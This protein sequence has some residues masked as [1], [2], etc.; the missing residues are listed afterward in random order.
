[1]PQT[2]E[3]LFV[4]TASNQDAKRH[5]E[6]SIANAI[7]PAVCARHFDNTV[8][9]EV[10]RRSEDGKFYAWGAVPGKRNQPNWTAM[11][12]GDHVLVYQEG[13]YTYW[14]RVISKHKN[15]AF[16]ETL[17]GRDPEGQTWEFMYFLQPSVRLRCPARAT[18]DVLPAQYMG[19]TAITNDKV[20]RLVSQYG[21]VEL[22]RT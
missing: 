18:A 15:A 8:L 2:E 6:K 3:H 14:T 19:F 22:K 16:A 21:S 10:I 17:W 5:I 20:Q 1:M 4:I 9:D 12:A 11:Q 7:D 13:I